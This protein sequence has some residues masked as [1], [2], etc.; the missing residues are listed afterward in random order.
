[1][2]LYSNV[3]I[4]CKY[5]CLKNNCCSTS[6][7]IEQQLFLYRL[8]INC[9]YM[10]IPAFIFKRRNRKWKTGFHKCCTRIFCIVNGIP[11]IRIQSTQF[12]SGEHTI[13]C[14]FCVYNADQSFLFVF[15]YKFS[16]GIFFIFI[17]TGQSVID[18]ILDKRII[19][20][21]GFNL[22]FDFFFF[23]GCKFCRIQFISKGSSHGNGCSG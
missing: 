18:T 19:F 4:Y 8:L 6:G 2:S 9:F 12:N 16:C 11:E 21:E 15:T 22:I 7:D 17:R 10:E 23:L 20:T 3:C 1:M 13:C 5:A 14:Q